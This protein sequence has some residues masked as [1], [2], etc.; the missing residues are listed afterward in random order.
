FPLRSPWYIHPLAALRLCA[1]ALKFLTYRTSVSQRVGPSSRHL[2]DP[3]TPTLR[4]SAFSILHSALC[5]KLG[6]PWDGRGTPCWDAQIHQCLPA[7]GR[8][9]ARFTLGRRK[10][11]SN[12]R[13]SGDHL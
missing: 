6:R 3:D 12:T 5:N 1:F 4:L 13:R 9:D 2:Y 8:R 10:G 11:S 7:L